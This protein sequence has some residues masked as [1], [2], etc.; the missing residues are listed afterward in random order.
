MFDY[1]KGEVVELNPTYV[2]LECRGIG[3]FIHISLNTFTGLQNQA[4]S[5]KEM[6]IFIQTIIREDA[7][8]LYG[9]LT[10]EER[11]LF[12]QLISVSGIG[13]NT[14]RMILSSM[15]P[16]ELVAAISGGDITSLKN[17]KG[18]G[19]KTAQRIIVEL[20]DK[21]STETVSDHFFVTPNN[22]IQQEALSALVMLGFPKKSVEKVVA[23]LIKERPKITVEELIKNALKIL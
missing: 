16:T 1:I 12:R 11:T 19:L 6:K 10:T 7:H 17:V 13:A 18:I 4:P 23:D 8:L 3:Y 22:T 21:I 9:F 14:A 20:K 2:V 15:S 5:V